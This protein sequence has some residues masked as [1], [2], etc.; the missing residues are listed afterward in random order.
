VELGRRQARWGLVAICATYTALA[1]AYNCIIPLG[2]GPDEPRHERYYQ[3]ILE[4]HTLPANEEQTGAIAHHPP[5]YYLLCVPFYALLR[6]LGE[7]SRHLIRLL[8][9]GLGLAV[10]VMAYRLLREAFELRI[11]ALVGAACVAWLP[12]FQLM[13]AVINNDM[14][15]SVFGT[16]T[17]LMAVLIACRGATLPRCLLAGA[18]LGLGCLTKNSVLPLG[19]VL[20]PALVLGVRPPA[21]EVATDEASKAVRRSPTE[22][23]FMGALTILVAWL[24]TGGWW[25]VRFLLT[26]GRLDSDP[27]WPL[28]AWPDPSLTARVIRAVGGLYRSTWPLTSWIPPAGQ[29][30]VGVALALPS[31]LACGGVVLLVARRWRARDLSGASA[32]ALPVLGA[33][34]LYAALLQNAVFVNPG[35]FEGA[36]YWLPAVAGYM[37]FW[38]PASWGLW[39]R[40]WPWLAGFG[41]TLLMLC[42][43]LSIYWLVAY[44]NPTYGPK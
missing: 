13:A 25:T 18:A 1:V 32:V 14:L 3:W 11:I 17:L 21:E 20:V 5:L 39:R 23:L 10:I 16:A 35:R 26:Y 19:I 37:G 8:S 36:R 27:A 22:R 28:A 38:L 24:V 2:Y 6:P 9:T 41:L 12:H 43:G 40:G 7:V 4:T 15:A 42:N 29:W 34:A 44:L 31:I 33:L 30:P